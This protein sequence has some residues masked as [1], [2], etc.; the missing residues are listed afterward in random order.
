MSHARP[1][2]YQALDPLKV[3]KLVDGYGLDAAIR[4]WEHLGKS[5]V[6]TRCAK[7]GDCSG[8]RTYAAEPAIEPGAAT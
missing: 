5:T 4:R 2:V 6:P 1:D 3:A 7:A 8:K